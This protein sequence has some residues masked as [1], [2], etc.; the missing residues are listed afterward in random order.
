[1]KLG[2]N[3][4]TSFGH[5]YLKTLPRAIKRYESFKNSAEKIGLE[6]TPFKAIEGYNFVPDEYEIKYRPELYPVPAN[7]Y[8]V[9]NCYSGIAILL[10]AMANNYESYVTCDDD[11]IF[12][13]LDFECIKPYF[14]EDWDIIIL[15]TID[16]VGPQGPSIAWFSKL[17]DEP[18]EIAGS[19][20]IAVHSR[21]YNTFL[22]EMMAFDIHGR[23]GDSLIHMLAEQ[24]KV[25]LYRMF[26]HL[27]YQ[28]RSKLLPYTI[29]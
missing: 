2:E 16:T 12:Y 29:E 20:C 27:T 8:L 21:F 28:E 19:S 17:D 1:M 11:T 18:I 14:P 26:P 7:K 9:G 10:D 23:I 6:Y 3:L 15:G 25:N 5:V 13:D 24:N 4:N 22:M